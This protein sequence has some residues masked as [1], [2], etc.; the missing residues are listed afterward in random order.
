[1]ILIS[2]RIAAPADDLPVN[3]RCFLRPSFLRQWP[4]WDLDENRMIQSDPVHLKN[5]A[6]VTKLVVHG[7]GALCFGAIALVAGLFP[8]LIATEQVD[9]DPRRVHAPMWVIGCIGTLFTAVGLL[10]M[11]FGLLG[12]VN[13]ARVRRAGELHPD[14]P[15]FG[16]YRWR[17]DGI[18]ESSGWQ[19]WNGLFGMFVL[20]LFFAV[21]WG[22]RDRIPGFIGTAVVTML[23][24]IMVWS[25]VY[26]TYRI[27]Q[28]LSY[29]KAWLRFERFPFFLGENLAVSFPMPRRVRKF[30]TI[31]FTLRFVE[32]RIV[33]RETSDGTQKSLELWQLYSDQYT[34]EAGVDLPADRSEIPVTF[35]LP[36][37]ADPND[38]RR[39]P[40]RYWSLQVHADA[41][42]VD[43]QGNFLLPVYFEGAG[44][45]F[46][47]GHQENRTR[48]DLTDTEWFPCD[49]S[50]WLRIL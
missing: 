27:V 5:E 29:A 34:L 22:I 47:R 43:Y 14:E 11:G 16:D 24:L 9:I 31:T 48:H 13:A 50:G 3:G 23:G 42:G 28:R 35:H 32:E 33:E 25:Y 7:K 2:R 18:Y 39:P 38:L 17:A 40:C 19:V 10:L 21:F 36:E 20:T 41:P 1:M 8:L 49:S 44:V 30:R 4:S 12:I 26:G 6:G 15:W 46:D 45:A 37:D